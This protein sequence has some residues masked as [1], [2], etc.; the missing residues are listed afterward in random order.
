[1]MHSSIQGE[2]SPPR[3]I[4]TPVGAHAVELVCLPVPRLGIGEPVIG[5]A[6]AG[7]NVF[8]IAGQKRWRG[9]CTD[10][11]VASA[12]MDVRVISLQFIFQIKPIVCLKKWPIRVFCPG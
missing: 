3:V 9:S 1:M 2:Y 4:L 7:F 11:I 8:P 10:H 6:V 12:P 5:A